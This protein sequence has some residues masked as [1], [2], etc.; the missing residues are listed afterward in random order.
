MKNLTKLSALA[1]IGFT[2]VAC[3]NT[4]AEKSK[5]NGH[6]YQAFSASI[7]WTQ[8]KA[9]CESSGGYL[10]TITSE[11]EQKFI[12]GLISKGDKNYYWIGGYSESERAFRWVTDEPMKFTVWASGEPNNYQ[13]NQD[14]MIIYRLANPASSG[15]EL[16][17][18]DISNEGTIADESFFGVGN[19]GYIC[20]WDK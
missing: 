13:G 4:G 3:S 2:I 5:F 7:S 16:K 12:E 20:E 14:K 10:A 9:Q 1:F 15:S 8:A 11:A 18:D 17:W 19:F 6:G